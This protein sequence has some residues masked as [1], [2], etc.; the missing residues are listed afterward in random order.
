[1]PGTATVESEA[2]HLSG[3]RDDGKPR[4]P[5]SALI[6][7]AGL[8]VCLLDAGRTPEIHDEDAARREHDRICA[9]PWR[10]LTSS[11]WA[12]EVIGSVAADVVAEIH[13]RLANG[14]NWTDKRLRQRGDYLWRVLGRAA[15]KPVPRGWLGHVGL[16][17]V[18]PHDGGG[19]LAG[20]LLATGHTAHHV[21]NVW[22]LRQGPDAH[23]LGLT[24]LHHI[25][26]EHVCFTDAQGR[27]VRLRLSPALRVVCEA[28]RAG[29]SDVD[30]IGD[31]LVAQRAVGSVDLADDFLQRLE[32]VGLL[33]RS[34]PPETRLVGRAAPTAAAPEDGFT[35]VYRTIRAVV[36]E[37]AVARVRRAVASLGR[38][39]ELMR[40]DL[41]ME[42]DPVADVIGDVP[43]SLPELVDELNRHAPA[44]HDR[45]LGWR[46]ANDPTSGYG[47][48]LAFVESRLD[49]PVVDLAP[50]LPD[51]ADAGWD[52]PVDCLIRPLSGAAP[53]GVLEA[54][55]S[56]GVLDARFAEGLTLGHGE[57]P[58]VAAYRHF[59]RQAAAE[60]GAEP[61]EVMAP[62][63]DGSAANAVRRPR[64]TDRWTGDPDASAYWP[65]SCGEP[66]GGY[67]P[68]HEITLRR[69][70]GR[71]VAESAGRELWLLHH[72][73][74]VVAGPWRHLMA[75]ARHAF[76]V[77]TLPA[78]E[79]GGLLGAFPDRD[80]TPR[81]T[82]GGE[83]V[84]SCAQWRVEADALWPA[85]GSL[86]VKFRT[87]SDLRDARGLPR[88][89]F[90]R[91]EAGGKP[92]PV[93]LESLTAIRLL[94]RVRRS[95]G[96]LVL[97]EMLPAPDQ[98]VIRDERG[99]LAAQVQLRLPP[100]P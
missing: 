83:L 65:A 92:I 67:V 16:V 75:L 70:D 48:L 58:Q 2:A 88:W 76:P 52:W 86:A 9:L 13:E 17:P 63:V 34:R 33:Q 41:P 35:D 1:M 99:L 72:S 60:A 6:R 91:A 84:V 46:P 37:N 21:E 95:G 90:A 96:P 56:A 43:R 18:A 55:T 100:N 24:A 45:G 79:F 20:D 12:A 73:T 29:L 19:L 7:L 15:G 3:T 80:R 14:E 82:V 57:P 89:V 30:T 77:R 68:P 25:T 94:D 69:V 66:A 5:V 8:P 64:Y 50:G 85:G 28:L 93:D 36:P 32:V 87:L 97:E 59:L 38:V 10:I 78:M 4:V 53:L 81:V 71:V 98:L 51:A 31:A 26:D 22:Q 47:R 44:R 74:R 23:R 39:A 40:A 49:E 61:V 11:P 27:Q 42:P 54:V 62:P